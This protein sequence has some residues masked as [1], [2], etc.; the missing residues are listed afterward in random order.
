MRCVFNADND[1]MKELSIDSYI[2]F[3]CM[4]FISSPERKAEVNFSDQNLSVVHC[5]LCRKLFTFSSSSPEPLG[6]F[7]ENLVQGSWVKGIQDCSNEW[8]HPFPRG[9]NYKKAKINSQIFKFSSPEPL[10]K[11]QPKLA[12]SSLGGGNS[13]LFK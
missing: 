4:Y 9:D 8:P 6:H 10:G 1:L 13:S 11:F 3:I 12:Q 7:Q 5:R 2:Y